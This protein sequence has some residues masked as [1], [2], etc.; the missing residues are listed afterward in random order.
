MDVQSVLEQMLINVWVVLHHFCWVQHLVF[1]VWNVQLLDIKIIIFVFVTFF[2]FSFSFFSIQLIKRINKKQYVIQHVQ[3]V[4]DQIQQIV[5]NAL[6]KH[7]Y[8]MEN[9]GV[10]V[11]LVLL[12]LEINVK[13]LCFIFIFIFYLMEKKNSLY[14]P[15][16][17]L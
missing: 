3:N 11:L 13:V 1:Q 8:L 5:W 4:M 14:L 10:N 6:E 17:W 9:V 12:F 16:F 7:I 2:L 15:M